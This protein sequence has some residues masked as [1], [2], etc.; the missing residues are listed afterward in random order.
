MQCDEVNWVQCDYGVVC[1]EV[2]WTQCDLLLW[3]LRSTGCSVTRSTGH[4]TCDLRCCR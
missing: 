4:S 1:D 3:V 2:N